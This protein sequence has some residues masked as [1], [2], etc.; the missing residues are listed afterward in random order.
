MSM[1]DVSPS[2]VN[3]NKATSSRLQVGGVYIGVVVRTGT[4]GVYVQVPKISGDAEYGPCIFSGVQPN[5][6]ERMLVGFLDNQLS[7]LI[8]YGTLTKPAAPIESPALTGTPTAPTAAPSTETNQIATTAFV[9]QVVDLIPDVNDAASTT[10]GIIFGH[11]SEFQD[12][13][14]KS[15]NPIEFTYSSLV[16]ST[17]TLG[18]GKTWATTFNI[19][20]NLFFTPGRSYDVSD[21]GAFFVRGILDSYTSNSI[22]FRSVQINSAYGFYNASVLFVAANYFA[23]NTAVGNRALPNFDGGFENTALGSESLYALQEAY[24]N[25]G[26]VALGAR[27]LHQ[28]TTGAWNIAIGTLAGSSMPNGTYG[29]TVI[30]SYAASDIISNETIIASGSGA[31][32]PSIRATPDGSVKLPYQP[33][34]YA[35]NNVYYSKTDNQI[36]TFNNAVVNRA[37][38]YNTATSEFLVAQDGAYFV[39]AKVLT[40]NNQ[41]ACDMR[42]ARN[43][44]RIDAYA[45]YALNFGAINGYKQ[46]HINGVVQCVA[47]DSISIRSVGNIDVFG[48][49]S[50]HT[51]LSI[52]FLG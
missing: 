26:N 30:G 21:G 44:L 38:R 51:S 13:S 50:G 39:A 41:S 2:F 17:I 7:Q 48:S 8:C 10:R 11:S 34:L 20:V 25:Y 33:A 27:S 23:G 52:F 28:M 45:G 46:G 29:A 6:G 12:A 36:I 32:V 43:G 9:H 16:G 19:N 37:S 31:M 40:Q 4:T 3:R 14:V 35:Y 42:I 49:A 5:V 47:G 24:D 15:G 1:F 18:P 22:T